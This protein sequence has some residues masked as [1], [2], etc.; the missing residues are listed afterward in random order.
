M[1]G[2]DGFQK[3]AQLSDQIA[4]SS[5]KIAFTITEAIA[6]SGIGRTTIYELM[7]TGALPA[8]K[9]GRKTLIPAEALRNLLSQLPA[10]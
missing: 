8:R 5:E 1:S 4:Q 7:K 3:P 10:K 2:T 9:L 6:A